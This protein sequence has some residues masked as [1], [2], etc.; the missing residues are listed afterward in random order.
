[1]DL[2]RAFRHLQ[3]RT[4]ILIFSSAPWISFR[5][6][7]RTAFATIGPCSWRMCGFVFWSS[8]T[9]FDR[10]AIAEY[11]KELNVSSSS[12]TL[13]GSETRRWLTRSDNTASRISNPPAS[14]LPARICVETR[15]A[16]L[17]PIFE[18]S[19]S[20]SRDLMEITFA[21]IVLL[22]LSIS[23][24][25]RTI[26]AFRLVPTFVSTASSSESETNGRG[27]DSFRAKDFPSAAS[28]IA[29]TSSL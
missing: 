18:E 15:S 29:A 28:R 5:R 25:M 14:S 9:T 7:G 22:F 13:F 10:I 19:V 23:D 3:A 12:T 24:A 16:V 26:E 27:L 21:S 6:T 4:A 8:P 17:E 20:D 2:L 1:M 11:L